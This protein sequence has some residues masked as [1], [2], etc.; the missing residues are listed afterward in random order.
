[1]LE[2]LRLHDSISYPVAHL[3]IQLN[4]PTKQPVPAQPH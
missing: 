3:K 4:P 1:M 2:L